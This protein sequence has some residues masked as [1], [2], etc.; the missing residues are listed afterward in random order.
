VTVERPDVV[1]AID[2]ATR[3]AAVAAGTRD[4]EV[5]AERSW[6][7]GFRHGQEVLATIDRMLTGSGIDLGR[8]VAVVVGTGPGAFT[9]LR[10]GIATAKAL[11]HGL[12]RPIA[13]IPS[14]LALADAAWRVDAGGAT[15]TGS[16][17]TVVMPAGPHDR[18]V[19]R[20][21]W[22]QGGGEAGRGEPGDGDAGRGEP[23]GVGRPRLIAETD[24]PAVVAE[25]GWLVVAVDLAAG[26][27]IDA[28][29]VEIG[30]S[31]QDGLGASLLRLG[32]RRIARGDTDDVAGLVPAYVTLPRGIAEESGEIAWSSDRR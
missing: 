25:A 9:G 14:T 17:M 10:V 30:R 2:T 16:E 1:L 21:R 23:E 27:S 31:A 4:G 6:E 3:H 20:Y 12:G 22:R 5:I 24:V 19:A 29:S 26:G 32:C 13:G 18:Y 7:C 15:A 28:R 11:A 8:V